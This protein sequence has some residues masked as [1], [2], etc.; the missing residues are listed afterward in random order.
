MWTSPGDH[1][2]ENHPKAISVDR[3]SEIFCSE[4]II[5][6]VPLCPVDG[7]E[8]GVL[9]HVQV[10]IHLTGDAKVTNF[11]QKILVK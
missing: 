4:E 1:V 10:S 9:R 2:E 8:L 7:A 11:R 6:Q 5:G 3:H